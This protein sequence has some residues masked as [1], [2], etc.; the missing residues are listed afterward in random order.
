M[1]ATNISFR[2][3]FADVVPQ[4]TFNK[5]FAVPSAG[6]GQSGFG[7]F[8][9]SNVMRATP[10]YVGA[11]VTVAIAFEF[12]FDGFSDGLWRSMNANKL[13][14]DVIPSRFP[15]MP[16]GCGDEDDDEDDEDDEDEE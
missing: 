12:F 3:N 2:R 15:N 10:V 9:Y 8:I 7:E 11:T 4:K 16:P 14:D 1:G 13:F 5:E 6:K